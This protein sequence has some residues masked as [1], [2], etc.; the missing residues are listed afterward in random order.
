M[1]KVFLLC[2]ASASLILA[3][4]GGKDDKGSDASKDANAGKGGA[5]GGGDICECLK[6]AKSED[7]AKKCDPSKSVDELK[8]IVMDCM[9][10]S[11]PEQT[12]QT[13]NSEMSE[14]QVDGPADMPEGADM[15][16]VP[17]M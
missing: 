14:G 16:E 7:D 3:S 8:S 2:V 10:S 5:S 9:K 15:P 11:M 4:C 13:D 1:K 6:S 17:E 12:E